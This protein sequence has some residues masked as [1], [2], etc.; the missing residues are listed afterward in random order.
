MDKRIPAWTF[1]SLGIALFVCGL[2]ATQRTSLSLL[3]KITG[4]HVSYAKWYLIGGIFCIV[5]GLI[6]RFRKNGRR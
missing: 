6:I 3:D 1:L 2:Y 5:L 4:H